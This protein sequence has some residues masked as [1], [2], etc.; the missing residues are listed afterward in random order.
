MSMPPFF[1]TIMEHN[2]RYE[3]SGTQC[4]V[5]H[6]LF[7]DFVT[8]KKRITKDRFLRNFNNRSYIGKH[9]N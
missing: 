6:V 7:L 1:K 8:S 2:E 4:R 9:N 3:T 5:L